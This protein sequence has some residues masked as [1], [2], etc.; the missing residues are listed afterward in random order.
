MDKC[1]IK[2]YKKKE[3]DKHTY[4]ESHKW[5]RSVYESFNNDRRQKIPIV[6]IINALTRFLKKKIVHE[7]SM[8]ILT[9]VFNKG[10][11]IVL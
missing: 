2:R 4:S 10:V 11:G 1:T 7:D 6:V 3:S 8:I 5:R 9:Y